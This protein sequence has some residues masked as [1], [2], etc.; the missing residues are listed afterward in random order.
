MAYVLVRL[1]YLTRDEAWTQ[2]AQ[3]QLSFLAGQAASYPTAYPMYLL[4]LL[5]HAY[6]PE[7]VTVTAKTARDLPQ[8][9]WP[10]PLD[11]VV[12]F[13]DAPT[14]LH[15]LVNDQTTYA[16]CRGNTCLP[17]TNHSPH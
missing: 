11:A 16:V 3:Q 8:Q 10:F 9:P 12:T 15:P 13:H 1:A 5:E 14:D 6:P 4:A 17:L 7:E 2:A